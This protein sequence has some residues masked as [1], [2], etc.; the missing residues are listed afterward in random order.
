M[1]V[2]KT[3]YPFYTT[4][5]MPHV[6]VTIT[7]NPSLAAI[8]RYIRITTIYAVRNLHISTA[9]T[10]FSS[11]HCNDLLR[12]NHW[13]AMVFNE[14]TH[15]DFILLS[16]QGRTELIYS[17]ELTSELLFENF[18]RELSGCS[19]HNG[20][21]IAILVSITWNSD[22]QNFNEP[23]ASLKASQHLWHPGHQWKYL[24]LSSASAQG[25]CPASARCPQR[26][27][28]YPQSGDEVPVWETLT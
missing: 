5:K 4:K 23:R 25:P 11:M 15:H 7:K 8:A 2:H 14:T 10:F 1:E 16:K 13:I 18:G 19:P 24:I 9:G 20:R 12:N 26:T 21:I 6:T 27:T 22:S 3:L 28:P 17:T